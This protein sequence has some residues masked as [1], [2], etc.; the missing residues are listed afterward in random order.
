M[1]KQALERGI[2][3]ARAE[4]R[5]IEEAEDARELAG[6]AGKC[7]KYRNCY[8]C[9]QSEADKWWAYQIVRTVT[10]GTAKSMYFEIDKDGKVSVEAERY[11][12]RS[13]WVPISRT[14]LNRAWKAVERK[15][16][17]VQP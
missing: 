6:M 3:T 5:D 1:S 4:L 13:G 12:S 17:E 2:A 15:L 10:G 8:S 14:E 9:P 7:F 11:F 16:R